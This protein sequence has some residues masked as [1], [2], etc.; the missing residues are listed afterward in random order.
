MREV[1]LYCNLNTSGF[2]SSLAV[3]KTPLSL[4]LP[5][6]RMFP[7]PVIQTSVPALKTLPEAA[8]QT[9]TMKL[10]KVTGDESCNRQMSLSKVLSS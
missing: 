2:K 6:D 3:A 9:G 7:H 1:C 4:V 5:P 10:V 8:R